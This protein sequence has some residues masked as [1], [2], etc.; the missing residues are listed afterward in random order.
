MTAWKDSQIKLALS[1]A[2]PGWR[3]P[4]VHNL[5]RK[6]PDDSD[7]RVSKVTCIPSPPQACDYTKFMGGIDRGDQ[8][9]AYHTCSRKAQYWWKKVLYFLIDIA[10]VNGYISYMQHHSMT[11][12]TEDSDVSNVPSSKKMTHT[13]FVLSLGICKTSHQQP[14]LAII[15]PVTPPQRCQAFIQ[16][17]ADGVY[18]ITV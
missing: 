14:S 18:T 16:N 17:S 10:W 4:Y 9:R 15:S 8:L 6:I 3:D 12:P 13:Q 2:H 7:R 11:A 1:T 5:T